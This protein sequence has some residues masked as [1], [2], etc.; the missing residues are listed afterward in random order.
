MAGSICW[1]G[2]Q[3]AESFEKEKSTGSCLHLDSGLFGQRFIGNIYNYS[4]I[5]CDYFARVSNQY[6]SHTSS[7]QWSQFR[8]L[9]SGQEIIALLG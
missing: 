7:G 5:G 6:I 2:R 8:L 3:E 4:L 9:L 1:A